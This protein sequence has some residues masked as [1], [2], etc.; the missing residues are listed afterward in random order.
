[1]I[2]DSKTNMNCS[3]QAVVKLIASNRIALSDKV[4]SRPL[5]T[6]VAISHYSSAHE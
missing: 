4:L 6:D 3:F 5:A 1:M 2:S